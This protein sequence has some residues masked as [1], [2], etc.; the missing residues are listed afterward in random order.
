MKA[1]FDLY[2]NNVCTVY[3]MTLYT[4]PQE[5]IKG[6]FIQHLS[7]PTLQSASQKQ[8]LKLLQ[9]EGCSNV[10]KFVISRRSKS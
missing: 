7:K 3:A 8:R 10:Q 5:T 6:L 9:D 4:W 1:M 2:H